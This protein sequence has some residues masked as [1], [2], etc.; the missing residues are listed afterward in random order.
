LKAFTT[1][2]LATFIPLEDLNFMMRLF[3]FLTFAFFIPR[4]FS[5]ANAQ[6]TNDNCI[7]AQNLCPNTTLSGS[8]YGSGT[9]ICAG[10]ADGATSTG[11]FCF[12]INNTVWFSFTTN[13]IGGNA[14]VSFSNLSCFVGAGFDDQI[15]AVVIEAGTPCNESTYSSVSNC[16][17]GSSADFILNAVG[18]LPNTTYFVQVNG[19]LSGAGI[20]DAAQCDFEI[21]VNGPAVDVMIDVIST[22]ANCGSTDGTITI[23]SVDGGISPYTF[24]INGG[25]FQAGNT[26]SSLAAGNYT[27]TVQD[28]NGCLFFEDEPVAQLGGPQNSTATITDASCTGNNGQIQIANTSGGTPAYIYTLVGGATQASTTFS[29]LPAGSYTVIVTDQDGCPDTVN[30]VIANTTGPTDATTAITPSDCGQSTGEIIV[31][32][33]GGTAPYQFSLDGGTS[34]TSAT[35]SNLAAGSYSI[36]V[37]DAAGCTFLISGAVV[38]ENPPDQS[39]TVILSQ[40]PMPACQGQPVVFTGNVT[41]G[42]A[43]TNFEFFVNGASVQNGGSATFSSSSLND[44]DLV[45]CTIT[46]NDPCVAINTDESNLVFIN[47]IPPFTPT[48]TVSTSTPTICSGDQAFFTANSADCTSGGTFNWLVNGSQVSSTTSNTT[49]LTLNSDAQVSV[50]LNC[51]DAC[52]IQSTSNILNID[53]TEVTANAGADQMISPG[54]STTLNGSGTAGGTFLWTPSTSLSSASSATPTASPNST[55]TYLLT[56]TANGCTATDD[57]IIVVSTLIS[58]PNTF[59]PNSDGTNDRWEISRIENFA[60]CKVTVYDR[61]GQKVFNTV[62][63]TNSNAWDG[64]NNGL[65]LPA[66]TYFYVI[67]LNSGFGK[68]FD[69]YNGSLTIVY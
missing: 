66:S 13:S 68:D 57:V 50:L 38:S 54:E 61:W 55:T 62:G 37:T 20:T 33:I 22:P 44:G 26:F 4:L 47:V 19:D 51:N 60:N 9:E 36:V 59:T 1:K 58:A 53:V 16:E 32:V 11:N 3:G 56:V 39:P 40:S 34:Q 6:T 10:C 17:A 7:D 15:Q 35:F 23:N 24:A 67:D 5:L 49:A 12:A 48:T 29:N 21:E 30:A 42:G 8:T 46:S 64:T 63:Y 18:L 27:I 2:L 14:D 25:T 41:N 45:T 43:S 31:T 69:I 52:A 65:K 28:A